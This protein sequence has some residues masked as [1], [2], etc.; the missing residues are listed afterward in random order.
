MVFLMASIFG[1]DD[2][3]ATGPFNR[4]EF[5]VE[6]GRVYGSA[7]NARS[8]DVGLVVMRRAKAGLNNLP[9]CMSR[10]CWI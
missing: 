9:V 7:A 2:F 10:R 6:Y 4:S 3:V 1:N 8:C 5:S